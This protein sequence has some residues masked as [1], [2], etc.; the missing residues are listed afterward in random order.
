MSF[1]VYWLLAIVTC[2]DKGCRVG[3]LCTFSRLQNMAF[4]D[5]TSSM[6]EQQVRCASVH[7]ISGVQ[8]QCL[9]DF[10]L[11]KYNQCIYFSI[12]PH[13]DRF[14]TYQAACSCQQFLCHY[15]HCDS[16][17]ILNPMKHALPQPFLGVH[18]HLQLECAVAKLWSVGTHEI[19]SLKRYCTS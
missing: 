8:L 6:H 9:L 19:F 11:R 10:W 15:Y 5:E 1:E 14:Y 17:K 18:Y 16:W 13:R 3:Q 7:L 12:V 4:L 2:K